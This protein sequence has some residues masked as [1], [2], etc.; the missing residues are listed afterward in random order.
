M[1]GSPSF[2]QLGHFQQSKSSACTLL[3]WFC[4]YW[5]IVLCMSHC[6]WRFCVV[7]C[8]SMHYF[9]SF[10]V[11][12]SSWRG[13]ESWLLCFFVFWM[14]CY[15]KSSVALLH[16]AVGWAAVCD[17]GISWSYSLTFWVV[18]STIGTMNSSALLLDHCYNTRS[19]SF[20]STVTK[21]VA[22]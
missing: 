20:D 8:F 7:L 17:C 21:V 1:A 14:S 15:F 16:S 9:M 19:Q 18:C 10:L 12:Q 22:G 4:C 5:F 11:L 3:T 13:R 6:L 2:H